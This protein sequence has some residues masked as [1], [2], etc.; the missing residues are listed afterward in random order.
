MEKAE[1]TFLSVN[2]MDTLFVSELIT[3]STNQVIESNV[4]VS[5]ILGT[6]VNARIFNDFAHFAH[7][8]VVLGED[9][10]IECE[11]RSIQQSKMTLTLYE[12]LI[13][14]HSNWYS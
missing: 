9:S 12:I 6:E 8:V 2:R 10:T 4:Y 5:E 11:F 13:I 14:L 1:H 7:N 3:K